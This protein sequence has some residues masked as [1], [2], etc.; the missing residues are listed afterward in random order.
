MGLFNS[1]FG[2]ENR[3]IG[4][5]LEGISLGMT[6]NEVISI[7]GKPIE[8]KNEVV[9]GIKIEGWAYDTLSGR[10]W[11]SIGFINDRVVKAKTTAKYTPWG[12]EESIP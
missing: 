9:N 3:K 1:L 7:K 2:K 5:S 12:G 10:Y 11:F 6:K 4:K 8:I